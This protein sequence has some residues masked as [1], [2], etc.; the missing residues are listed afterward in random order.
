MGETK[1]CKMG[2]NKIWERGN[3]I[4]K[5]KKIKINVRLSLDTEIE[6]ISINVSNLNHDYSFIEMSENSGS[7]IY[8]WRKTFLLRY[9]HGHKC[10]TNIYRLLHC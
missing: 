2:G 6:R 1:L 9:F 4:S 5:M 10:L 3:E 8:L 7:W